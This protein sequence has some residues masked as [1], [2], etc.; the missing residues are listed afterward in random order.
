[1][2]MKTEDDQDAFA[3]RCR[4]FP[5]RLN[6]KTFGSNTTKAPYSKMFPSSAGRFDYGAGR[7]QRSGKS[8]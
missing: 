8:I 5:A 4:K 1:M 7:F 3:N 2:D 6:S